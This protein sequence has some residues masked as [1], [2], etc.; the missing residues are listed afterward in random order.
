MLNIG[1]GELILIL[2][3]VLIV[4]GHGKLPE[5]AKSMGKAMREFRKASSSLQRVWDDVTRRRPL[6]PI[7]PLIPAEQKLL[8]AAQKKKTEMTVCQRNQLQNRLNK[9]NRMEKKHRIS[10]CSRVLNRFMWT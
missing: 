7:K 3:V 8:L 5:V 4:F 2:V 9:Q 6:L 10:L 1:A